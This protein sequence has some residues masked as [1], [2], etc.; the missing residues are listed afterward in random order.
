ML[1]E[2]LPFHTKYSDF[3]CCHKSLKQVKT[4][5]THNLKK[6]KKQLVQTLAQILILKLHRPCS[7]DLFKFN[8]S[9]WLQTSTV[10]GWR[11]KKED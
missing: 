1:S 2:F 9:F 8:V 3:I 11:K 5:D 10:R 4:Y 6:K 7:A